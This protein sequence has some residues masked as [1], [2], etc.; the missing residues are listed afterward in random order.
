MLQKDLIKKMK[1][2]IYTSFSKYIYFKILYI[3][4]RAG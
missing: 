4:D 3:F 1:L 2:N